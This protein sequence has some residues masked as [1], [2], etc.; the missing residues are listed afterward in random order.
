MN[1]NWIDL[2]EPVVA[3][4]FIALILVFLFV[5]GANDD[6]DDPPAFV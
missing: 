2:I 4:A 6:D 1:D 3:Y 5:T